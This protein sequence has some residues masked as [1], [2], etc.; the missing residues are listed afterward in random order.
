[1]PDVHVEE[2]GSH[3]V[4]EEGEVFVQEGAEELAFF[5]VVM[6]DRDDVVDKAVPH[7]FEGIDPGGCGVHGMVSTD[8]SVGG[9][10][11]CVGLGQVTADL[12]EYM[13]MVS[14]LYIG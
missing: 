12:A 14:A 5:T 10:G 1:M 8:V 11:Q 2:A 7:V 6:A 9:S 3:G 13:V 4:V